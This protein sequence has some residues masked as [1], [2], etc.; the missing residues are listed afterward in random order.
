MSKYVH[1]VMHR[2]WLRKAESDL[3]L[4]VSGAVAL[5]GEAYCYSWRQELEKKLQKAHKHN[6]SVIKHN[7]NRKNAIITHK[8]NLLQ[9]M[10][11]VFWG[12]N[13]VTEQLRT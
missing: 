5:R 4:D 12:D 11:E 2:C 3:S 7:R 10:P 1:L 8:K 13:N 9:N 6:E